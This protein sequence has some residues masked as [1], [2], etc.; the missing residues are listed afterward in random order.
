MVGARGADRREGDGRMITVRRGIGRADGVVVAADN[1]ADRFG[2]EQRRA[3]PRQPDRGGKMP[4]MGSFG[5]G[6]RA[7]EEPRPDP[8]D[9][10]VVEGCNHV[11]SFARDGAPDKKNPAG[12][13]G[14]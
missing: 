10:D 3:I 5:L 9:R 12:R 4:R 6:Q 7:I 11:M 2:F 13:A 14:R 8:A 1:V